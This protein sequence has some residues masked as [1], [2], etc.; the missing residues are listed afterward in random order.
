LLFFDGAC[1]FSCA[2]AKLAPEGKDGAEILPVF[3]D[4]N[5]ISLLPGEKREVTVHVRN[6][7][8]AGAKPVLALDGFNVAPIQIP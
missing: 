1:L 4:G 2:Q 6:S 3:F 8:L 7:D 5:Y